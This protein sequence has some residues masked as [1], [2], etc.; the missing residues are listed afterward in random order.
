MIRSR[1]SSDLP[2][3]SLAGRPRASSVLPDVSLGDRPRAPSVLSDAPPAVR[4]RAIS[5]VGAS[6]NNREIIT[7]PN[8]FSSG[9]FSKPPNP[10]VQP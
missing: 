3:A 1:A 10:N 9:W 6:N 7:L 8:L 5:V 2:D 4:P